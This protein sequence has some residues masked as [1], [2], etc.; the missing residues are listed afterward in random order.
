MKPIASLATLALVFF[1]AA[2]A[3]AQ[4]PANPPSPA[5]QSA[6]PAWQAAAGGKLEFEVA[7]VKQSKSGPPSGGP[8]SSNVPLTPG[9]AYPPNGGLFRA[10]R[11]PL[12]AYITFAYKI[13]PDQLQ[14]LASQMP[15]WASSEFFD[16]EARADGTPTKDQMRLMMQS[17]LADRFKLT[18]H[19]ETQQRSVFGLVLDKPG[20]TGP[21]LK[22]HSD[23]SPPCP[24]ATADAAI[25]V[26][27]ATVA[28]GFPAVCGSIMFV[29]SSTPGRIGIGGRDVSMAL[30]AS[31]LSAAGNFVGSLTRP[32]LDQTGLT[33]TFDFLL[34]FAPELPVG[35]KFQADDT[36]PTFLEALK[37]QLGLKLDP[38]TGRVEAITI[39][40]VEP[41]SEN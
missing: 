25:P 22:Q 28:G 31:T 18:L 12:L 26:A 10:T 27:T 13:E 5:I 4:P 8:P 17:L 38:Q 14:T 40:H 41:P 3:P 2:P 19:S 34:Q 16:I 1:T 30:I 32:V 9:E 15:K 35:V 6:V 33:G 20:K 7:S 21:Q 11:W 23:D 36:A 39:D 37:E 24:A 29:P